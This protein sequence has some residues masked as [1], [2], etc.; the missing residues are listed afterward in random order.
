MADIQPG[1]SGIVL[2]AEDDDSV[3]AL[4]EFKLKRAGFAVERVARGDV[5]VDRLAAASRA[6]K[7]Y[8]FAVLDG[9]LPGKDGVSIME[10]AS[11]FGWVRGGILASA[12]ELPAISLPEGW[13]KFRK[14]FDLGVLLGAVRSGIESWPRIST[15]SEEDSVITSLRAEFRLSFSSKASELRSLLGSMAGQDREEALLRF[16]HN[17]AGAAGTYG[18]EELSRLAARVEESEQGEGRA[19][20]ARLLLERLSSGG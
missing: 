8:V 13:C 12:D 20:S 16:A 15:S 19:A 17:L 7:P 5:A 4:V 2:L 1:A 14:P 9:R 3:A 11:A 10:E 6:G 18:F